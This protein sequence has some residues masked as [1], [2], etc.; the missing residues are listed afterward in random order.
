VAQVL[1]RVFLSRTY[2]PVLLDVPGPVEGDFYL[3]LC[4]RRERSLAPL[5]R[6]PATIV[7][8]DIRPSR[9]PRRRRSGVH[10]ALAG[11]ER[12]GDERSPL[13]WLDF[14]MQKS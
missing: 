8:G 9:R 10:D 7:H 13:D 11:L 12:G 2:V 14:W 6:L 5:S 4:A 1:E 3:D